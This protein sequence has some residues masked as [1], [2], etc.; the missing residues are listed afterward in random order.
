MRM[1]LVLF[2]AVAITASAAMAGSQSSNSSSNSS[3]NNG[4]VSEHVVETDC[5]DGRCQRYLLRRVYSDEGERR[6]RERYS[7]DDG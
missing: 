4:V 7:N 1:E 6:Y 5:E 3:T 2:A